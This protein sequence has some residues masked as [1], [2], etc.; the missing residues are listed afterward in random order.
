MVEEGGKREKREG[1]AMGRR[2]GSEDVRHHLSCPACNGGRSSS[3][4]L[5]PCHHRSLSHTCSTIFC[6]RVHI[7]V[8]I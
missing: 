8:S 3:L 1:D 2:A 7:R 6:V 4:S 5:L